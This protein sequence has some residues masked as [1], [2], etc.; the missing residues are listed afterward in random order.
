MGTRPLGVGLLLLLAPLAGCGDEPG[1]SPRPAFDSDV[2]A[3]HHNLGEIY[4]GL[5][6]LADQQ[7][8]QPSEGGVAFFGALIRTGFWSDDPENRARLTCP[9]SGVPAGDPP[10]FAGDEPLTGAHS[11]YAGRDLAAFPLERFPTRGDEP[12][13]ACDN[14]AGMNHAGVMNVLY[15]DGSIK[16]FQLD[17]EI[18][19]GRLGPDAAVIP[20]GP[21]SPLPDLRK[22]T[23]D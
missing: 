15:A 11:A 3:C 22:L 8:W 7:D 10:S 14:A 13:M 2:E 4:R 19:R 21:D 5:R 17:Q 9:G 1:E 6:A 18:E 16:T 20:V 12:L 23:L